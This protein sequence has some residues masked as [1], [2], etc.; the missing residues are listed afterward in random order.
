MPYNLPEIPSLMAW[1]GMFFNKGILGKSMA[2][3]GNCRKMRV[4]VTNF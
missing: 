3:K 4:K 2:A 1:F